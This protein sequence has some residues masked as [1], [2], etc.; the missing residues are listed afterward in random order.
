[1]SKLPATESDTIHAAQAEIERLLESDDMRY[2]RPD[3]RQLLRLMALQYGRLAMLYDQVQD[4]Q[5][6]MDRMRGMGEGDDDL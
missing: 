5:R 1:M 4:M 6:R 2:M 3:T